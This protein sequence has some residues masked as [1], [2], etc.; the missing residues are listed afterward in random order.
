MKRTIK[1]LGLAVCGTLGLGVAR[2]LKRR[3]W[4]PH[5]VPLFP[6]PA[7]LCLPQSGVKT[8]KGIVANGRDTAKRI[9]VSGSTIGAGES[10]LKALSMTPS[11][12]S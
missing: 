12:V 7:N 9:V 1:P 5:T 8:A 11:A 4:P 10:L 3:R 6:R 2:L